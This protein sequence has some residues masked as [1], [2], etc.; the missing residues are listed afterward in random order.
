MFDTF[1]CGQRPRYVLR[2]YSLFAVCSSVV[3]FPHSLSYFN[4]FA[5]GPSG[6]VFHLN[7]S[8]IDWGQDL[9]PLRNWKRAHL[10][11]EPLNLAYFDRVSPVHAGIDFRLPPQFQ[12]SPSKLQPGCYAV[13]VKLLQG[14][15]YR[16][17]S[18]EGESIA[19]RA[20]AY[21]YF[22]RA[23]PDDRVQ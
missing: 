23:W 9:L 5:R 17:E 20:N 11:N 8:N 4:E 2:G 10:P 7:N 19:C 18:P 15:A 6:G 22:S 13:S 3:G 21:S 14:R 12:E 1:G 16:V